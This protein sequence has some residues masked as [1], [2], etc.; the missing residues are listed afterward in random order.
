MAAACIAI[1]DSSRHGTVAPDEIE[2]I[3]SHAMPRGNDD[4]T[5]FFQKTWVT[6]AGHTV[7]AH[8]SS[9]CTLPSGELLATWYGGSREGASDVSLY[10]ARWPMGSSQWTAPVVA[11]TQ[12]TAEEELERLVKKVGNAVVFPD[13]SGLLWM[14]YVSVSVGGWSGSTLNVKTSRDEGRTW[15]ESRRLT[16]NPFFN[17]SSL[18]R[19][20]PIFALDGRIGLPVYHEL[21]VKFPQIL[22]LSAGPDGAV[23]DYRIRNL[24]QE[25]GLIQPALVPLGGDRVLMILRDRNE[26]RR[27]HTSYSEDN[28]WT[29]SAAAPTNLPNPDAAVDGLRLRDG[30]ILVAYNHSTTVRENLRLA[31]SDDEGRTWRPGPILEEAALQ[32]Y[33]YPFLIEDPRG[34]IHVTYTWHRQRIRHLEFNVAWL[35]G[36]TASTEL[37]TQ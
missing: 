33:S 31:V 8:S 26:T 4:A 19:N 21:A 18:V 12:G 28:G 20:K 27:L 14:V 13:R 22:W 1:I 7:S 24:S 5:P 37:V 6:P 25:V 30:R 9:I 17:L 10:T 3:R 11:V 29:W 36:S 2:V 32:E 34:R 16:L 15:G 23:R 35:D